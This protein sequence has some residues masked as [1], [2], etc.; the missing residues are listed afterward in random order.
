MPT[1]E[2]TYGKDRS[3]LITGAS[4]GIGEAMA[5][6]LAPYGGKL[7]LV[8]R[9]GEELERVA[10]RVRQQG[11]QPL[12]HA[13]DVTDLEA[14]RAAHAAVVGAQGPV[15]VAFL[16]AGSGD[17]VSLP[18]FD[19]RR[20]QRVFEVNVF[21]VINWMEALLPDMISRGGGILAA[22]SSLA[23]GRGMPGVSVYSATKAAL[24]SML[25]GYRV[26]GKL[27][28]IQITI[29][30]PGFVRTPIA[31]GQK[32]RYFEL[33]VEPAARII[34]DGVA[35]GK[36]LIRFPWQMAAAVQLLRHMPNA[37]YDHLGSKIVHK[38]RDKTQ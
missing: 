7:A 19:A 35:E 22:T 31:R 17:S 3:I 24:S 33:E 34:I 29:V 27:Y 37:L 13:C 23:A 6:H 12:V 11:G 5:D 14:V 20:L 2:S 9:R 18:R 10:D 8:A 16:N 4:S 26:E 28:G 15:D 32:G 21:G 1:P 25:D 36:S 38:R 30:E